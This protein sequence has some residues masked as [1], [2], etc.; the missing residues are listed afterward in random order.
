MPLEIVPSALAQ[1]SQPEPCRPGVDG[2]VNLGECFTLGV[3][4]E[5]VKSQFSTPADL[6]NPVIGTLFPLAGIVLFL[7]IIFAGF[8]FIGGGTKGRD[9]ALQILQTAIVGMAILF[10][11]FWIVRIIGIITQT[12]FPF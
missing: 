10:S 11:A 3:G 8:K 4:E 7:T 1:S 9:E 2:G 12:D 5:P 6:L